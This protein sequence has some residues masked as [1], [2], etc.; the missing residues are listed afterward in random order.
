MAWGTSIGVMTLRYSQLRVFKAI[1]D[2]SWG[3]CRPNVRWQLQV[4]DFVAF[5]CAKQEDPPQR[6]WNYFFVGVGTVGALITRNM[7]WADPRYRLYRNY[8]NV[9]ATITHDAP[10]H[11]E[12][13]HRYHD[14]WARR[15]EA[16]YVIFD[17]SSTRFNVTSRLRVATYAGT[18]LE[19]LTCHFFIVLAITPATAFLRLATSSGDRSWR[20]TLTL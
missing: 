6:G 19:E 20:V 14:D 9:L 18:V 10:E 17:P 15:C 5:F 8:Y 2:M 11:H 16:P 4:N 7:L 1:L 3:V 12:T 13:F